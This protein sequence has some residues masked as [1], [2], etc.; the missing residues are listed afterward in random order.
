MVER[1]GAPG[2]PA[3]V[4]VEDLAG[5]VRRDALL[6][7]FEATLTGSA[8]DAPVDIEA[9][10]GEA[11]AGK[12]ASLFLDLVHGGGGHHARLQFQGFGILTGEASELKGR[13]ELE[14][15]EPPDLW[16]LVALLTNL[17]P[18]A[19]LP[20]T[21]P[22]LVA[23]DVELTPTKLAF[24][25]V[26]AQLG[27]NTLEVNGEL[28]FQAPVRLDLDIAAG[29][30]TTTDAAAI[31]DLRW[32]LELPWRGAPIEGRANVRFGLLRWHDQPIQQLRA[33]LRLGANGALLDHLSA[34]LPGTADLTLVGSLRPDGPSA[35][36]EGDLT[37]SAED[38]R[39]TL[40]TLGVPPESLPAGGLRAVVL[41]SQVAANRASVALR[42][43][44][45]RADGS[46]L[47]G[48]AAFVPGVR[49]RFA[50]SA[51]ADRLDLDL[52]RPPPTLFQAGWLRERLTG[53]D[54]ALDLTVGRSSLGELWAEGLYLRA[55]L[56]Q[57][58]LRVPQLNVR[59]LAEAQLSLSGSGDLPV[60]SFQLTGQAVIARPARL[61][62][63]LGLDPPPTIT[64]FAPVRLTGSARGS[65]SETEVELDVTASGATGRLNASLGPW[66]EHA[67][68]RASLDVRA[69]RL[70]DALRNLGLLVGERPALARPAHLAATVEP[71]AEGYR[72]ALHAEAPPADLSAQLSIGAG[73]GI[74]A[75]AGKIESSAVDQ[76]SPAQ[77]HR[78]RPASLG[79]SPAP[80][81]HLLARPPTRN[82]AAA[83]APAPARPRPRAVD[84]PPPW[85]RARGACRCA[86]PGGRGPGHRRPAPAAAGWGHARRRGDPGRHAGR[87]HAGPGPE[88]RGRPGRPAPGR[89]GHRTGARRRAEPGGTPC[90]QWAEHGRACR[91]ARGRRR[92]RVRPRHP[93]AFAAGCGTP[94]RRGA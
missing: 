91:H 47:M 67:L 28:G 3:R 15:A 41:R 48:S 17:R 86:P 49:P 79:C 7:R 18:P 8:A 35:R 45:L 61:L 87:R 13:L 83:G 32:L 42:N 2:A 33:E 5:F 69:D 55:S 11:A 16:R 62:R 22:I 27:P 84:R 38:A 81:D 50:L 1:E 68:A 73:D 93:A 85:F 82:G 58:L 29:E 4:L 92:A 56:E 43:F 72:L 63:A 23:G 37:L 26:R 94:A 52:Y 54:A 21:A 53:V 6:R 88:A 10:A 25:D 80:A 65:R 24:S 66:F 51:T 89:A 34:S 39:G 9:E 20:R 70:E 64:R 44:E 36:F 30:L 14:A 40:A 71:E 19:R 31:D 60:E 74:T 77:C 46:R 76:D 57:G 78:A 75:I 59:D 12:P 90:C